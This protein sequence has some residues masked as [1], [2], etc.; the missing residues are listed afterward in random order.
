MQNN[1]SI[2]NDTNKNDS[3]KSFAISS[4]LFVLLYLSLLYLKFGQITTE[5]I[6][7]IIKIEKNPDEITM[8]K[9][10]TSEKTGGGSGQEVNAPLSD[11]FTPQTE[12][13]LN[14]PNSA[15]TETISKGNS[16]HSNAEHSETNEASTTK[17]APNPFG[18]G[19]SGG[20]TQGGNGKGFGKDNGDGTGKGNGEGVKARIRLNDPNTEGIESDQNA[21]I[22]MKLTINSEGDIIKIE[23]IVAKTTTTNQSIINQ[24]LAN[25]KAQ[26]KY[27]KKDGAAPEVVFLT[28]NLSAK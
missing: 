17:V 19:G 15:S 12:K 28:V 3:R 11:K 24:V 5:P 7:D 8:H 16:N 18:S 6:E 1:I 21:K 10:E 13:I 23:N 9:F 2:N 14:D 4:L 27:N 20:G 25:V 26:V 22:S